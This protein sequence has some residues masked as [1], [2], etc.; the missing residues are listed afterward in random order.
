MADINATD[1]TQE[2]L[3]SLD[4]AEQFIMF[5]TAE[6]K[7]AT[8]QTVGEYVLS[9]LTSSLMGS[10]QTIQSAVNA[11]NSRSAWVFNNT[12]TIISQAE[13]LP[14]SKT[15]YF[16]T[17][18]G[19]GSQSTLDSPGNANAYIEVYKYN[20]NYITIKWFSVNSGLSSDVYTRT[21]NAG[22]WGVW[23]KQ[24]SRAEFDNLKTGG[25]NLII[26]TLSPSVGSASP[27][28]ERP[29]LPGHPFGANGRGICTVAEHGLRFTMNSAESGSQWEFFRLGSSGSSG[30]M[31]GL[32]LGET[33]TWSF[34]TTYKLLSG[35]N[36][37][38]TSLNLEAQLWFAT[39]TSTSFTKKESK[40]V[41]S[42][43]VS[44]LS[45]R[46]E[47]FTDHVEF[48][49]TVPTNATRI[50]LDFKLDNTNIKVDYLE[51][52]YIELRNI[53]LEKGNRAS[54]WTPAPED[55]EAM[56]LNRIYWST[57]N[58][59]KITTS[60]T[61]VVDSLG[62]GFH[63]RWNT[64]S[65]ATVVGAPTNHGYH[66][67]INKMEDATVIVYAYRM[68]TNTFENYQKQKYGV[69]G[70]GSWIAVPTLAEVEAKLGFFA[71][72]KIANNT[73]LNTLTTPGSYYA[74]TPTGITNTPSGLS[75]GVY[76]LD[77]ISLANVTR[78][79]G[80]Y[81]RIYQII[82]DFYGNVW[83]RGA[84]TRGTAN[85]YEF[86]DW[87][88]V[89][90]SEDLTPTT[91]TLTYTSNS[92]VSETDFNRLRVFKIGS[93]YV[94][95]GNFSITN[96]MPTST[97]DVAIGTI[98]GWSSTYP[99]NIDVPMQNG[100]GVAFISISTIGT[101]TLTNLSGVT[102]KGW[103]KFNASTI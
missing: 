65:D 16:G 47:T 87:K 82:T 39:G 58:D 3:S 48:T 73:N 90:T 43:D 89:T 99:I 34:D 59:T 72:T 17:V 50:Y 49:F 79:D 12:S 45:D 7:R 69:D 33:Y 68:G 77:T 23:V 28:L 70:W 1:L 103:C 101:V 8:V 88:K 38:S 78:A 53:K 61:D 42:Y 100:S 85:V 80:T 6:G 60:L 20:D 9:K 2:T 22:T 10:T 97:S 13:S 31:M 24:P 64:A 35:R 91:L 102:I 44:D 46:G 40:V 84:R 96:N 37:T 63:I 51:G 86:D 52:D 30:T 36:E 32:A 55:I 92:Y 93:L 15:M 95:N 98:S 66:Y 71:P 57:R 67:I 56:M 21:K 76:R 5:D 29:R 94:C 41:H 75:S 83:R 81:V 18:A 4:G 54:D 62:L 11:L 74:D 14:N 19:Y 25:R 27:Y 26:N